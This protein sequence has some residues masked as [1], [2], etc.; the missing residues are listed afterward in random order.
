MLWFAADSVSLNYSWFELLV[1]VKGKK[2]KLVILPS[3]DCQRGNKKSKTEHTCGGT[4]WDETPVDS[5]TK[6]HFARGVSMI[7]GCLVLL[8]VR[9][10]VAEAFERECGWRMARVRSRWWGALAW[11]SYI[12]RGMYISCGWIVKKLGRSLHN[13]IWKTQLSEWVQV[14]ALLMYHF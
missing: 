3:I 14:G 10:I 13:W 7:R 2:S 5:S 4:S 8:V 6:C 1:I 9:R 12:P 11:C